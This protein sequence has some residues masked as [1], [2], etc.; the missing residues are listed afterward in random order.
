MPVQINE[1]IIKAVV[2]Q[3]S[4]VQGSRNEPGRPREQGCTATE[5]LMEKLLSIIREKQER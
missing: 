5:E 4:G 1:V 2:E 3:P